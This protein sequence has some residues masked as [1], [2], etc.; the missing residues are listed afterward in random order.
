M[1]VRVIV[2]KDQKPIDQII[3]RGENSMIGRR[4]DCEISIKDPAISGNHARIREVGDQLVIEDLG[5]TNGIIIGGKKVKQHVLQNE[6]LLTIGEHQIRVLISED[7]KPKAAPKGDGPGYIQV[8]AGRGA[9][10]RIELT[11]SLTTIGEPGVQVAAVSRRPQGHFIVHVDGG[12]NKD[13]FP[14]VNGEP[15]GFKSR[16]LE[17]GD[18]IEVAGIQMEYCQD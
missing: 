13:Q 3:L 7:P 14:L 5:S 6:D 15:T 18:Q 17:A 9:G 10:D 2:L 1:A 12:K 11:E 16:K 4:S 8:V